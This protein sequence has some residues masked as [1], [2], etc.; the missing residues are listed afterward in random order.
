MK[1]A[2]AICILCLVLLS[3]AYAE[4]LT[5]GTDL[6]AEEIR[7][8]YYTYDWVGYNAE[9]H[10]YRFFTENGKYFFFHETRGTEHDYGWNT[11]EDILSSGTTELTEEEWAAFFALLQG[12]TVTG[13][14]EEATDG[15]AGPWMYLYAGDDNIG[16]EYTFPSLA[17]RRAFVDFCEG[18]AAEPMTDAGLVSCELSIF[19]GMENEE[20]SY[21]AEKTGDSPQQF[22]LRTDLNGIREEYPLP[23][24]AADQLADFLAGMHPETWG[25][26]PER[27]YYALDAP[28]RL[29]VLIYEDGTEYTVNNDKETE[30]PLF[31]EL[32]DFLKSFLPEENP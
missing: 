9:Y 1:K 10:R 19:G 12:G 31:W 6:S 13:R 22:L 23:E 16:Q 8:F 2:L 21:L 15:D 29:I 18:L 20:I 3:C 7:D 25:T 24:S 4:V 11:E 28:T 14:S 5:V 26:L 27:E 32:E 17:A 30:R